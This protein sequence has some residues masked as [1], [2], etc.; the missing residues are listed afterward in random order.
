[1]NLIQTTI[2]VYLVVIEWTWSKTYKKE[3][4]SHQCTLLIVISELNY[5]LK[6]S[7]LIHRTRCKCTRFYC[8]TFNITKAHDCPLNARLTAEA[9]GFLFKSS[10]KSSGNNTILV[11]GL[12]LGLIVRGHSFNVILSTILRVMFVYQRYHKRTS[13]ISKFLS[14]DTSNTLYFNVYLILYL[15]VL[16]ALL[17]HFQRLLPYEPCNMQIIAQLQLRDFI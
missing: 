3:C 13:D 2:F 6:H 1:M 7:N 5:F 14:I 4:V 15:L 9:G 12:I 17:P 11:H 10:S 16:N 8:V